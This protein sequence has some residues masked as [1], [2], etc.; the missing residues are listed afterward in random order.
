MKFIQRVGYYLGG[1]AVGLIV[2]A[3]FLSGKRTSCS[4]G[5][6]ARV[7]KNISTK[8]QLLSNSVI[9]EINNQRIDSLTIAYILKK[10][11]VNF[12]ESNTKLETCKIY[13]IEGDYNKQEIVLTVENCENTATIQSVKIN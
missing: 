6:D 9:A 2:L 5:P 1:F 10:G 11:D 8:E 7:L 12:S 4:Y 3:F 13:V